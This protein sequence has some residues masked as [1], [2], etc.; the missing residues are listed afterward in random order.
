MSEEF[1][2]I[3]GFPNYQVSNHGRV[4][5]LK[6][7]KYL[8]SKGKYNK[9][10]LYNG[11]NKRKVH[12]HR[13]GIENFGPAPPEGNYE[14]DHKDGNTNNNDISNL[15]YVSASENCKNGNSKDG[16]NYEFVDSLPDDK[17]T[18]SKINDNEFENLYYHNDNFWYFTG[19]RYRKMNISKPKYGLGFINVN[20]KNNHKR[21]IMIS[22]FKR[23]YGI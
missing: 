7:G 3:E 23:L 16:Q 2:E 20:D 22:T 14:I 5:S 1:K 6:T 4:L 18:V 9:L 12:I 8:S 17:I 19:S 21:K 15:R 13:L 11:S 10:T